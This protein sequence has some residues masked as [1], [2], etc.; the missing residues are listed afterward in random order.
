MVMVGSGGISGF[1]VY[2]HLWNMGA[3]GFFPERECPIH[4][5]EFPVA[6]A[7]S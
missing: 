4:F 2:R 3:R 1:G 5:S 6:A 7:L